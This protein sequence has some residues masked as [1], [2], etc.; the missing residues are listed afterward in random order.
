MSQ[1]ANTQARMETIQ[2]K[3]N[4]DQACV[5]EVFFFN[6]GIKKGGLDHPCGFRL[7]LGINSVF[8]VVVV[9]FFF[10]NT[11]DAFFPPNTTFHPGQHNYL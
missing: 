1:T 10:L 8:V 4:T 6:C 5:S 11:I 7:I 2:E 9:D 3:T